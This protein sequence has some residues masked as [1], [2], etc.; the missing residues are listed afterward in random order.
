MSK[1]KGQEGFID[2]QKY[3]IQTRTGHA[4]DH[5]LDAINALSREVQRHPV[6]ECLL[7]ALLNYC[8]NMLGDSI[9][10]TR[11]QGR[12]YTLLI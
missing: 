8:N 11:N 12:E 6:D 9:H 4:I 3:S 5:I 7:L 1:Q 10:P 2:V